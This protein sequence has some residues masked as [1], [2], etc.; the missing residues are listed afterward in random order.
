MEKQNLFRKSV[1]A[2][3]LSCSLSVAGCAMAPEEEGV[4]IIEEETAM[5]ESCATDGSDCF[6]TDPSGVYLTESF[7]ETYDVPSAAV[8]GGDK[9]AVR[10]ESTASKSISGDTVLAMSRPAGVKAVSVKDKKQAAVQT[11]VFA[12]GVA[13]TTAVSE[14]TASAV[15]PA[16]KATVKK[17]AGQKEVVKTETVKS[18]GVAP[19]PSKT[20]RTTITEKTTRMKDDSS[21]KAAV[22]K[23]GKPVTLAQKVTYGENTHDWEAPAGETLR[24]LLMKWGDTSGWTVVWKLDRDYHLEAGVVFRGNFVDASGAIIRSFARATPAPIG[25][26]YKGNRV[27]VISTQEDE[28]ER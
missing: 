9:Q 27:L 1:L 2:G 17:A 3:M 19:S 25:T 18:E 8:R 12:D 26:F 7:V 22:S 23:D 15:S 4:V 14:D 11:E 28:N 13:V 20:V 5:T 6:L 24:S 16:P 21:K 10:E